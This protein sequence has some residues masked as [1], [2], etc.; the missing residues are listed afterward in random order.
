[1]NVAPRVVVATR[2]SIMALLPK[3]VV[4]LSGERTSIYAL[5]ELPGVDASLCVPVVYIGTATRLYAC[6]RRP[7]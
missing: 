6:P 5:C 1:M 3:N 2:E 7:G 4:L